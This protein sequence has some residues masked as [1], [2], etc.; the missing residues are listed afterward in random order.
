MGHQDNNY[1][2][3]ILILAAT[4]EETAQ[5]LEVLLFLLEVMRSMVN[6]EKS[7]INPALERE[8]FGLTV[9][10]QRLQFRL[11]GEKMK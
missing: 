1:I 9:D 4:K 7:H 2:D 3:D 10:S 11:P 6:Q 5:H 8:F